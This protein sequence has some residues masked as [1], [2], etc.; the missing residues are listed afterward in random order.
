[1]KLIWNEVINETVIRKKHQ[2]L[3][4]FVEQFVTTE[5]RNLWVVEFRKIRL[6]DWQIHMEGE[7]TL[8]ARVSLA[9]DLT[10]WRVI[11]SF[12]GKFEVLARNLSLLRRRHVRDH[13]RT[14][15][16]HLL[17]LHHF[18]RHFRRMLLLLHSPG[19]T[20]LT[21]KGGV[22]TILCH[23]KFTITLHSYTYM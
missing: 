13:G 4:F 23:L 10:F 6:F 5:E 7:K 19:L 16:G 3:G 18:L 8:L 22:V 21:Q 9:R 14:A 15:L 20:Q 1:M 12:G 11:W 17:R 2:I